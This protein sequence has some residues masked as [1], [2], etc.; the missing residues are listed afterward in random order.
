MGLV[1]TEAIVLRTYNLAEADKIVVCLTRS[2]GL[3]RAVAR[4]AKRLKSRFGAGLEPFTLIALSYYEKEGRE[5][6][7]LRQAEILR[8]YFNLSHNVEM[9]AALAYMSELVIEF[10]PPHEPNEKLFRMI[11]ACTEAAA[12]APSGINGVVRYFEVWIL[13]LAGFLPD[14]RTCAGCGRRFGEDET[15]CLDVEGRLRCVGCSGEFGS[16]LSLEAYRH[17]RAVQR[18]SPT[19]YIGS[20]GDLTPSGQRELARVTEQ[21][22]SRVLERVPRGQA[23]YGLRP[24]TA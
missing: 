10:A 24:H 8:S 6:V 16:A 9:V 22:I 13:K 23:N 17:L 15:P 2:A 14:L 4:G 21:M 3:V 20:A 18:L 11:N 5:L 12:R 19:D 7:S 1:E